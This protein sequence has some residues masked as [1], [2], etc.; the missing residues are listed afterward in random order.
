MNPLLADHPYPPFDQIK[1]EHI[2]DAITQLINTNLNS[3]EVLL[4]R[5]SEPTWENSITLIEDLEDKLNQAWSWVSHLNSVANTPLLRQAYHQCLPKLTDYTTQLGQNQRLYHVYVTISESQKFA[6]LS[7]AQQKMIANAVRDF[8]LS[9]VALSQDKR[10]Q[11]A[12]LSQTLSELQSKFQDNVMDA[13]DNWHDD[14]N[15]ENELKGLPP[16]TVALAKAAAEKANVPGWRLTLDF[17][18]FHAVVTYADNRALRQKLHT[19]YYTRASE[20]SE[21]KWDNSEG[22]GKIVATRDRLAKLL[23]F[24][25]YAQR[26]LAKKMAKTPEQVLD[27]LW[28]LV[29][30]A[31]PAAEKE[32]NELKSFAK[33]AFGIDKLESWDI[34]YYS[35]KLKQSEFDINNEALRQYFP[36]Q[37]VLSGMFEVIKRLYGMQVT[38][39]HGIK[40]YHPDVRFFEISDSQ[41]EF[42]GAFYL[43][44]YARSGKRGGAW[45]DEARVRRLKAGKI[46]TPIAYLTC[47][48][49]APSHG[50]S[51]L[52]HDEVITLFHEFG[53]GLHHLLTKVDTAGVSGINGVPWDAVELPSQF[54]ENWCWESEAL[55]FIANGLPIEILNKM[56]KAKNFQSAMMLLRQLEF[57]LFDFRIH[58]ENAHTPQRIQEIL[59]EVRR[60][61]SV[62]PAA[63]YSR[64]QHSFN[65]I[66]SGGYAAGYYSYLW[67]EV[68]SQDA[69]S[70][71][72]EEG[73]FNPATGKAFLEIILEKGG[74]VDP[75]VLFREFRGRDP[76]IT[77]LLRHRG[78]DA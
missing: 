27:F 37:Q 47:N 4:N 59:D 55:D 65:H 54:M 74:S 14:V 38:E 66:F 34:A 62:V 36:I 63:S 48:F 45:M 25:N 3:I 60:E 10:E 29:K 9:G 69:F 68:L 6:M 70:R 73:I 57:S 26:S 15:D 12:T 24:K 42:R 61:V 21:A 23:D 31:K 32:F 20:T 7:P 50:Q 77:A 51:F 11:F 19:A 71:F 67:A 2:E 33:N 35:E 30:K 1:P 5:Q 17:P 53:H 78:I 22:M 46:Q 56:L 64:F 52:T 40:M 44:L 8:K 75:S 49:G 28:D 13:T 16:H 58:L 76:E 39:K 43:D 41:G 18:C 72:E